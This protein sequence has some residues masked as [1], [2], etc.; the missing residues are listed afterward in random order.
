MIINNKIKNG[1]GI[2]EVMIAAV[3]IMVVIF[4]MTAAGRSALRGTIYMHERA[5]A[6][7]LAQ[8]GIE[9]TRQVR[10]SK[11]LDEDSVTVT[12][13]KDLIDYGVEWS[14]DNLKRWVTSY[15][16]SLSNFKISDANITNDDI[17]IDGTHFDRTVTFMPVSGSIVPA[18]GGFTAGAR[19]QS[20]VKVT[21]DVT[22]TSSGQSKTISVS[23]IL[24]NWR[25]NY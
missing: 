14:S 13:F 16:A 12:S 17:D 5:Q 23:E 1:F 6:M 22:W 10:D 19:T 24:T 15:D 21:V 3:I 25:M 11:W 18:N 4:A 2:V 20:V 7:Y 8:E 9:Q